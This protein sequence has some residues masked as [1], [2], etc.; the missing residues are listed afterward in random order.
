M[1]LIVLT[2]RIKA[3]VERVFDLSRSIDLHLKSA[4]ETSERAVGGRTDG[5]IEDGEEVTWEGSHFGFRQSLQVRI[6]AMERPKHF[7]DEMV[8][9]A[10]ARMKHLHRYETNDEGVTT[11][12][13]EFDYK[14]RGGP[15]GWFIENSFLTAYLRRFLAERN[16]VIKRVA[17]S[18]EW[19][20]Y[21]PDEP[22]QD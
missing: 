8:S 17:E 14:S 12:T 15:I 2:T 10:F 3:P 7:T 9:G 19:H 22:L 20:E 21:L 6:V 11:M 18:D 1:P 13:D 5:L 4:G 16:K